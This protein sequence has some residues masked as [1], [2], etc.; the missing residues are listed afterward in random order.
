MMIYIYRAICLWRTQTT[1][2]QTLLVCSALRK[3]SAAGTAERIGEIRP[4]YACTCVL[5]W[6]VLHACITTTSNGVRSHDS[7][8]EKIE[9][10][11]RER[12]ISPLLAH[13][14]S[15]V[16]G[17]HR[18]RVL[19]VCVLVL[20]LYMLHCVLVEGSLSAARRGTMAADLKFAAVILTCPYK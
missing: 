16:Q 20:R 12:E 18:A 3:N 17:M 11:E 14:H 8:E 15:S 4:T 6:C 2:K 7:S 5:Y 19:Y 1:T 10:R 9:E 13:K